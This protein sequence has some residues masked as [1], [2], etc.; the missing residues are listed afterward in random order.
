MV[1]LGVFDPD[2]YLQV[3]P[4]PPATVTVAECVVRVRLNELGGLGT[5]WFEEQPEDI[6]TVLS[7]L[8]EPSL[9]WFESMHSAVERVGFLRHRPHALVPSESVMLALSELAVGDEAA[10]RDRLVDLQAT[11]IG[12]WKDTIRGLLGRLDIDDR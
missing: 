4:T 12:P 7:L 6:D 8:S 2:V 3:W 10:G 9:R 1:E 11:V 5:V